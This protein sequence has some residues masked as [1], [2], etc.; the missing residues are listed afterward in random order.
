MY[1]SPGQSGSESNGTEE[2]SLLDAVKY[3]A[4]DMH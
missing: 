4:Q 1:D 2:A 3:H